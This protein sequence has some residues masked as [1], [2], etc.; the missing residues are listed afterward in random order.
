MANRNNFS[1][2]VKAE[3]TKRAQRATGFQCE[4]KGC[5]LIVTRGEIHHD[6][7]DAMELDKKRKLTAADG[8]FLCEPCHDAISRQQQT[9]LAKVLRIEANQLRTKA[10]TKAKIAAPPKRERQ[11]KPPVVRQFQLYRDI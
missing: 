8:L 6:K 3:I 10:S 2:A 4:A 11:S 5:G 1:R 7:Q 9:V